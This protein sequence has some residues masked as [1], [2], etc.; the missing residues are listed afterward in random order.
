MFRAEITERGRARL[1]ALGDP[2]ENYGDPWYDDPALNAREW[3]YPP[4]H[5][6]P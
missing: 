3:G 5:G 4:F 6:N 1:H 2:Y